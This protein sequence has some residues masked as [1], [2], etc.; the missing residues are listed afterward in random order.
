MLLFFAL[1][2]PAPPAQADRDIVYAARYY[3][4][5][6]AHGTSHFHLYRINPDG[7]GKTQITFGSADDYEPA[8]SPDGRRILFTR[9]GQGACLV[10]AGGGAVRTLF[11]AGPNDANGWGSAR[12]LPDSNISIGHTRLLKRGAASEVLEKD[13]RTGKTRRIAGATDELLSPDG[14]HAYLPDDNKDRILDRRT[15]ALAPLPDTLTGAAWADNQTLM[16]LENDSKTT[17][18]SL[19]VVGTDGR[20]TQQRELHFPATFPGASAGDDPAEH[21]GMVLSEPKNT[22]VFALDNHNSTVGTD[23]LFFRMPRD[24]SAMSYLTEGQFLAWS[25]NG[26][27]FAVAPGR[28]TTNYDGK[29]SVWYAPLFVR[30]AASGPMRQITPRLSDVIGADWRSASS[31]RSIPS[32]RR[33]TS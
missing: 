33:R 23:F 29:R 8:W 28:D 22:L 30:A 17:R 2:V 20:Q 18:W 27:Q 24:G 9:D 15:G 1:I 26:R 5:P 12:W 6:G 19:H 13:T 21:G 14:K 3:L 16:G 4:P 31:P 7:T 32:P 11:P 10:A 25:P